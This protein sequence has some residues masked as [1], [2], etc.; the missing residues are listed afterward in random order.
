LWPSAQQSVLLQDIST[1]AADPAPAQFEDLLPAAHWVPLPHEAQVSDQTM[2]N[3]ECHCFTV[4]G[5]Q[6]IG[7]LFLSA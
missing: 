7:T 5:F 3:Q 2:L 6:F 1:K 4:L